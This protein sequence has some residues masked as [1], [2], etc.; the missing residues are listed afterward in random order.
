MP[1]ASKYFLPADFT[2][3]SPPSATLTLFLFQAQ[4]S[5]YN[6]LFSFQ[7]GAPSQEEGEEATSSNSIVPSDEI[8]AKLQES[9]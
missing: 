5:P 8:K 3:L 4:E 9:L 1:E 6:S 7:I 2:I